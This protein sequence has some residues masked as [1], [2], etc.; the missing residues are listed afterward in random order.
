M[1]MYN[2]FSA[3]RAIP[4]LMQNYLYAYKSLPFILICCRII[5]VVYYICIPVDLLRV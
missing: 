2:S 4:S 1:Y 3:T 5:V